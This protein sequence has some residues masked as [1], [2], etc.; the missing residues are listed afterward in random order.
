MLFSLF[1]LHSI[2][3]ATAAVDFRTLLHSI[4]SAAAVDL[5]A[6]S[7]TED[8][9]EQLLK[10][11]EK[12]DETQVQSQAVAFREDEP[13]TQIQRGLRRAES[14]L[15]PTPE[16]PEVRVI[17]QSTGFPKFRANLVVD[18]T[19]T[20]NP[21]VESSPPTNYFAPMP[22]NSFS[23]ISHIE[24]VIDPRDPLTFIRNRHIYLT[25]DS[26]GES[27]ERRRDADY[28]PSFSCRATSDS[29]LSIIEPFYTARS[30]NN[31]RTNMNSQAKRCKQAT[32]VPR[33]GPKLLS[34]RRSSRARIGLMPLIV[35]MAVVGTHHR[36]P[37]LFH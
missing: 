2:P 9:T 14:L 4:P 22:S 24:K 17:G 30:N 8:N 27:E 29:D 37:H 11:A 3:S 36:F 35:H 1:P 12:F 26:M 23:N 28:S 18:K 15:L 33:S 31:V 10:E 13:L 34:A 16:E 21:L 32:E 6:T 7:L 20:F 19:V 5:S 25:V